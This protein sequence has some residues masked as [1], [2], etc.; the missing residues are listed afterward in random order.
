MA[1]TFTVDARL[2]I[3]DQ[4]SKKDP[5][6]P[7]NLIKSLLE[8]NN[9][10]VADAKYDETPP[11]RPA[12]GQTQEG[13]AAPS[14]ASARLFYTVVLFLMALLIIQIAIKKTL[15]RIAYTYALI[16]AFTV[17]MGIYWFTGGL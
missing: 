16:G 5:A 3:S 10:T 15:R 12:M 14:G 17:L 9:Q 11:P 8:V 4:M 6:H 7:N 1:Q 2:P 13:F